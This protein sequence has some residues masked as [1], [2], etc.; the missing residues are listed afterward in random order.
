MSKNAELKYGRNGHCHLALVIMY[1]A[2]EAP[3][4]ARH[5]CEHTRFN[6]LTAHIKG[7][8]LP[9]MSATFLASLLLHQ[10][11][12]KLFLRAL[13]QSQKQ[14]RPW[15]WRQRINFL[16]SKEPK[17]YIDLIDW[18][19]LFL[20]EFLNGLRAYVQKS[21][22]AKII[23][24]VPVLYAKNTCLCVDWFSEQICPGLKRE[25]DSF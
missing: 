21:R 8:L 23:L 12:C 11:W 25:A 16:W 2:I 3:P 15:W 20:W 17:T 22:F 24:P 1:D 13:Q 19:V 7:V 10:M 9:N 4:P 18:G 14:Q 6:S 5:I